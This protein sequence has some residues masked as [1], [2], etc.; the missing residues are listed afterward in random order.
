[1]SIAQFF[2][3]LV[4]PDPAGD[5]ETPPATPPATPADPPAGDGSTSDI[6]ADQVS[7]GGDLDGDGGAAAHVEALARRLHAE[8]VRRDGRVADPAD[9]PFN[10]D[11]LDDESALTAAIDQA[12]ESRPAI[13]SRQY[14]GDIGAGNRGRAP[15]APVDLISLMRDSQ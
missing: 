11:H 4:K 12:V 2:R 3:D 1:M 15:A 7:D 6:D 13:R 10:P 8:L 14:G 5:A 9:I